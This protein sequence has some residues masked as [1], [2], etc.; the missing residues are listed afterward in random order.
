MK[1]VSAKAWTQFQPFADGI[2][3]CR[4]RSEAGFHSTIVALE[5]EGGATGW[6][7]A[8]PLGAWYSEAFA[9]G[10]AAGVEQLLPEV[11][12]CD[13]RM[14]AATRRHLD[15]V[16]F[17]QP[18][19]KSAIDMALWDLKARLADMPLYCLLGGSFGDRVPLYR[20][21]SEDV[22]EAMAAQAVQFL[23]AGYHRLQI[24]VGQDPDEDAE[25]V[26]A[27]TAVV[28]P[29][30]GV[31]C[32]ANGAFTC[33]DALTFLALTRDARYAFEQPCATLEECDAVRRAAGD[34]V[35]LLD[36]C[37]TSLPALRQI[38]DL[39][40]ADGVTLKIA[41]LG[42]VSVTALM[43]DVAVASGLKVCIEDTGGSDIDT[44]ATAH[45][46]IST[47]QAHRQHT[48]DFVNWVTVHNAVGMPPTRDGYLF[49]PEG[50]GLGIDADASAL[51][52]PFCS[53]GN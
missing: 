2:Y 38:L 8:A 28:P 40:C 18:Y 27:V 47:P 4:G 21:I 46:M 30:I 39:R 26:R 36:E 52:D 41:R 32:D 23:S 3:R 42:G 11:V 5:A 17:G 13:A 37:V 22:P 31:I 1:I 10:A 6:G 9:E 25:R 19:I 15:Q 43:R 7:E 35:M 24:K 12:G 29:G 34:R 14:T 20:S 33:H 51:G 48:V 53:V 49:V 45:L 16:M 50:P 44:A